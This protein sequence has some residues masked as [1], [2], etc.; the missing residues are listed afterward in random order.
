VTAAGDDISISG[1]VSSIVDFWIDK[2]KTPDLI[3]S[4]LIAM[5]VNG[6]ILKDINVANLADWKK[7]ESWIKKRPYVVGAAHAFTPRLHRKFGDFVPELVYEDQVMAFRASV[8][9]SGGKISI[10]LVLYRQGGV[11]Q[12]DRIFSSI[13]Y[14]NWLFVKFSRQ[15]SQYLQIK[16]DIDTIGRPDLWSGRLE[17]RLNESTFMLDLIGSTSFG[18]KIKVLI[19]T[20]FCGLIFKIKYLMYVSWPS[21][22]SRM[23]NIKKKP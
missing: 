19:S 15:N 14:V 23:R 3:T 11:S 12:G 4:N 9:G 5:D 22:G 13:N 17:C 10:P 16:K 21:L 20:P 6:S 2:G 18:S 7:P 1:R 8:M